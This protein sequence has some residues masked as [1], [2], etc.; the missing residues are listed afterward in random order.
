MQIRGERHPEKPTKKK[1]FY[2]VEHI[3]NDDR[4]GTI[5]A[6]I[7]EERECLVKPK[8]K[9]KEDVFFVY[10]YMWFDSKEKA[11]KYI[12]SRRYWGDEEIEKDDTGW[13][14]SNKRPVEA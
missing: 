5:Q 14:V 6:Q 8:D 10:D 7:V 11:M 13:H 4:Y 12:N 1:T 3:W 2:C 9:E